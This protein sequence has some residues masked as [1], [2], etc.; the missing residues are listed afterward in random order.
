MRT[1]EYENVHQALLKWFKNSGHIYTDNST[2]GEI[3]ILG[4]GCSNVWID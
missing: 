3:Y 2:T 1:Q 4:F